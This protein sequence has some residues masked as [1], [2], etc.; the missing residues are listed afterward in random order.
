MPARQRLNAAY[1]QGSV[2]IAALIGRACESWAAFAAALVALIAGN[3]LARDI[4]PSKRG[5]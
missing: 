1:F 5:R 4:R 2:L 3:L